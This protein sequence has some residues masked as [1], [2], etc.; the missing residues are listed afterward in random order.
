MFSNFGK[1]GSVWHSIMEKTFAKRYG[2][3]Q[4][5]TGGYL[6]AGV[7]ALNGSPWKE[8]WNSELDEDKLWDLIVKHDKMNDIIT[9]GTSVDSSNGISGSH[10]YTILSHYELKTNRGKVRLLKVR[11]PWG[12][13]EYK[14]PWSDSSRLWT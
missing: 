7:S 10:A 3:Y 11:N 2:N 6:Y 4:R 1:D 8:Y 5:M 12:T 13:E 14:G 9:C